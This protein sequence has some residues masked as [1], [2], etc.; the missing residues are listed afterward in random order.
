MICP[1]MVNVSLLVGAIL[2]WGILW[3]VIESKKGDWYSAKLPASSLHGI[4]GYR[5]TRQHKSIGYKTRRIM[6]L[7]NTRLFSC[8]RYFLLSR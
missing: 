2:S 7:I 1:Y 5:V 6:F 4:Q 3:P 8:F